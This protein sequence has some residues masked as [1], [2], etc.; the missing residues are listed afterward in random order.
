MRRPN[1]RIQAEDN[2]VVPASRMHAA[3]EAS[4]VGQPWEQG[5]RSPR[6][7]DRVEG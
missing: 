6:Q 5:L 7:N 2:K 4:G 3:V 1:K